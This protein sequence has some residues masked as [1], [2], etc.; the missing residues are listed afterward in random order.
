RAGQPGEHDKRVPGQVERHVFEVVLARPAHNETISHS[1]LL[2]GWFR[3][4]SRGH[5]MV[6]GVADKPV[7]LITGL[8]LRPRE[9]WPQPTG[10]GPRDAVAG[11]R[12]HRGVPGVAPPG[13]H[14]YRAIPIRTAQPP[15]H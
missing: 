10:P 11:H 13:Q 4:R 1:S 2:S 7:P 6:S 5:V 8:P 9:V 12:G 3:P 15:P 14:Y